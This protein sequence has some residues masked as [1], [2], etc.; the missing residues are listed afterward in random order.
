[1]S[2]LTFKETGK[3]LN[4]LKM[5]GAF[6]DNG[7]ITSVT[8]KTAKDGMTSRAV[9]SVK[10]K[11]QMNVKGHH[12]LIKDTNAREYK[13]GAIQY[14]K[15]DLLTIKKIKQGNRQVFL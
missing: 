15:I 10:G 1:M 8:W 7:K 9:K 4:N 5:V 13:G 3:A 11:C 14:R 6:L 2:N 12:L